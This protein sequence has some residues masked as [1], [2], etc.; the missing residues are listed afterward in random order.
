[1]DIGH[2]ICAGPTEIMG[3]NFAEKMAS[4]DTVFGK[5]CTIFALFY[6]IECLEVILVPTKFKIGLP[7]L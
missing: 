5:N 3:T 7:G 6:V 2:R 4:F 1:M